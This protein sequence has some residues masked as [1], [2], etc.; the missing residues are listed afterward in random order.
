MA[1]SKLSPLMEHVLLLV[2]VGLTPYAGSFGAERVG[3]GG[4]VSA[5]VGRGLLSRTE[6]GQCV[7]TEAGSDAACMLVLRGKPQ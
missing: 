3:R 1:A 5:L 6:G 2:A 4:T 7:L